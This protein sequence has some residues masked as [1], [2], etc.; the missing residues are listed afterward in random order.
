MALDR[1]PACAPMGGAFLGSRSRIKPG[2]GLSKACQNRGCKYTNIDPV[3]QRAEVEGKAADSLEICA[4]KK[5]WL[6]R[7]LNGQ[8]S[9]GT[10]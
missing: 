2:I 1:S 6:A 3:T 10:R 8:R 5:L 7:R 4:R 9:V